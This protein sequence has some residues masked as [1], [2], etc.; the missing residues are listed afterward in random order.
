MAVNLAWMQVEGALCGYGNPVTRFVP[1]LDEAM[2][3]E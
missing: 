3:D 1:G 2:P